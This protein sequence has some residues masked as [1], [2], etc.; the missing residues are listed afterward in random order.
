MNYY[1]AYAQTALPKVLFKLIA[2]N[3]EELAAYQTE[4]GGNYKPNLVV[5]ETRLIDDQDPDYIDYEYGICHFRINE[6]DNLVE[7]SAGEI[8]TQQSQ[9]ARETEINK[10]NDLE[11]TF[12]G[13]TFDYDSHEFPLTVAAREVYRIVIEDGATTNIQ[14]TTGSYPLQDSDIADFKTAYHAKVKALLNTAIS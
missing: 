4:M 12:A 7:R 11:V 8:S 6:V 14:S 2:T 5:A 9:L 13:E 10:T 3:D 1:E